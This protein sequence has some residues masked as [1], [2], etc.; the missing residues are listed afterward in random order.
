MKK[1]VKNKN[2]II[3]ILCMTIILLCVGF[4]LVSMRLEEKEAAGK[5]YDV[6]ITNIQ[7]GTAIRGGVDLPYAATEIT[8]NGKTAE[9]IFNLSYPEDTLTYIVTIKNNGNLKAKID[10]LAES[11]DYLE[12]TNQANSILPVI[13]NHNDII[14]QELTPGEEI[15]LTI[16]AEFSSSGQPMVKQIPYNISIL[17]SCID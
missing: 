5:V 11:P 14:N 6:E 4:S 13:I 10:G 1:L 3:M 9:F 17:T 2:I 12:D 7:E 16:T 15:K 8:D